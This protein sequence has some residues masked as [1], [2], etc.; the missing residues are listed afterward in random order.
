[1]HAHVLI[2]RSLEGYILFCLSEACLGTTNKS[3]KY[4]PIVFP[5]AC[6]KEITSNQ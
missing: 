4:L 1:M 6:K 2:F 3:Y 5:T